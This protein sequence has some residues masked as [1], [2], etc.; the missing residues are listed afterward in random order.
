[1]AGVEAPWPAMVVLL[2]EG[3]EGEE[4]GEG[5]GQLGGSLRGAARALGAQPGCSCS[6]VAA[7]AGLCDVLHVREEIGRRREEK[8][9]REKG[10]KRK[11]IFSN[12]EISEKIKDTLRSWSKIIF[13]EERY[14][15]NYK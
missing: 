12:L 15:P 6:F 10:E 8:R 4:D 1:M 7:V 11:K 9:R 14:L 13:V 3:R 5:V 2:G